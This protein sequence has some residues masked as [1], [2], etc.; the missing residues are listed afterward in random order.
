M[1]PP[2]GSLAIDTTVAAT[3]KEPHTQP[4]THRASMLK[5]QLPQV[6]PLEI[7]LSGFQRKTTRSEESWQ[8][9]AE[10]QNDRTRFIYGRAFGII[11]AES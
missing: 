7:A 9:Q 10:R 4:D 8:S 3:S 6:L 11:I 5:T 1:S 2:R